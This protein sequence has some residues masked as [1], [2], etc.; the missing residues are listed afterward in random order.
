MPEKMT[1]IRLS[2]MSV[3]R[4]RKGCADCVFSEKNGDSLIII[5]LMKGWR[6][7]DWMSDRESEVLNGEYCGIVVGNSRRKSA[8]VRCVVYYRE[9]P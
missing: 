8:L 4:P 3:S 2:Q 5:L 7:V 1:R 6:S 9:A